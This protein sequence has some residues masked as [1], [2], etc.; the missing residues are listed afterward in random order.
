MGNYFQENKNKFLEA[1]MPLMPE[2][3]TYD[4]GIDGLI[5][6]KRD[7]TKVSEICLQQPIFIFSVQGEKRYAVGSKVIDYHEGQVVFQGTPMASSSYVL[8]ASK[9]EPYVAMVLT[10]DMQIMSEL[11]LLIDDVDTSLVTQSV[12]SLSMLDATDE[13][14][15]SFLRL[16]NLLNKDERDQK[17]L[18]PLIIKEIYYHLLKTPLKEKLLPFA[19]AS[20]HNSKILKSL[21]YLK[22]NYMKKISIGD[23]AKMVN[24]SPAT[25][26]RH[27]KMVTT[28][29]PIHY[30]K[31]LRLL[32][33]DRIIKYENTTVAEAAFRVGYES[34]SQFTRE[35]KR[36]FKI[37]PG[38]RK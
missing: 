2:A 10:I 36:M 24:M 26:H 28:L 38:S 12:S 7:T 6:A 4:T 17:V 31:S 27:F 11:I 33:A 37:T 8:K 5:I 21:T 35:Y 9:D 19:I 14:V 1:L 15:D 22:E 3:T 30:Q 16:A 32:E 18:S 13:I 34:V 29:S 23:L 25:Y 20:S